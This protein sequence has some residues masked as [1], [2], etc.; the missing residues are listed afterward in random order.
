MAKH[1]YHKDLV[2]E[3]INEDCLGETN[4][5][6]FQLNFDNRAYSLASLAM[7]REEKH[8]PIGASVIFEIFPFCMVYG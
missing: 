2:I 5:Y 4:N 7:S 8:L 6:T 1:F 3:L